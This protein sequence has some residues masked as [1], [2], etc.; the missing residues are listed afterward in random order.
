MAEES[1]KEYGKE[2]A[3]G[4]LFEGTGFKKADKSSFEATPGGT[5]ISSSR[6]FTE[7]I[8]FDLVYFP[9]ERELCTEAT[10]PRCR[11][12]RTICLHGQAT[13]AVC[14]AGSLGET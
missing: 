5:V 12:R 7:G 2:E 6:V 13:D 11:R 1:F 3:I 9:Q 4:L 14:P 8:D 10:V